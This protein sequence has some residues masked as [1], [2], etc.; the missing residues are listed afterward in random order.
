VTTVPTASGVAWLADGR[1]DAVPLL[2]VVAI[3]LI[4]A[5]ILNT[6]AVMYQAR[7]ETHRREIDQRGPGLLAAALARCID[8]THTAA[9]GLSGT[10]AADEAARVR[11]SATQVLTVLGPAVATILNNPEPSNTGQQDP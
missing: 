11:A 6:A 2:I 4:A 5:A 3:L 7:H 1:R 9:V 8:D 10:D